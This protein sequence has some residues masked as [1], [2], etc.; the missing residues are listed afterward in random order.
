MKQVTFRGTGQ[1]NGPVIINKTIE[2]EDKI[3]QS[4]LG[5][6]RDDVKLAILAVHFPGVKI[7]PNQI[8]CEVNSVKETKV[9]KNS[10]SSYQ[11]TNSYKQQKSSFSFSNILLWIIFFPFKL[12]WWILKNI[13]K[14]DHMS[15]RK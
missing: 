4:L 3:A 10:N 12:V 1:L 14:D 8:G 11:K 13:W 15:N 2:L 9:S 7:K 5:P 6:K